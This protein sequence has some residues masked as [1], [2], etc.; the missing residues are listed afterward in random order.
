[1]FLGVLQRQPMHS[2]LFAPS[3]ST[4]TTRNGRPHRAYKCSV[5]QCGAAFKKSAH[6]RQHSLTHSGLKPFTCQIC[7]RNFVS[8]WVLKAHHLT[9]HDRS[10][11]PTF[12]CSECNRSFSTK[13]TLTRHKA[14]HSDMRPFLCPYC[15]KT[16]KTYSIC[17]KHVRTHSKEQ[18]EDVMTPS[19][20]IPQSA[21]LATTHHHTV[22]IFPLLLCIHWLSTL[23]E[24]CRVLASV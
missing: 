20:R 2:Q 6:L 13:G 21:Q 5:Q 4:T 8:R 10:A 12:P 14:S 7:L 11:A 3:G 1:M 9:A 16:F 24:L 17:K 19:S 15:P 23:V 18:E 22:R